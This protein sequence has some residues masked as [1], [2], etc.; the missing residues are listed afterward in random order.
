MKEK[1]CL[2]TSEASC[3]LRE[4]NGRCGVGFTYSASGELAYRHI[5][6]RHAIDAHPAVETAEPEEVQE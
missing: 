2:L 4:V 5:D 3:Y 6:C 1:I